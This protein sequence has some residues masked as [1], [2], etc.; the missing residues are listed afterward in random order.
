MIRLVVFDLDGTLV[1]SQ[2]DLANA[3]NALV[4]E[5]GGSA[6]RDEEVVAM[7][8]E[9][10]AVLVRRLLAAARLDPEQPGALARFLE[11]YDQR[12]TEN[13]IPYEGIE[14]VLR[15]LRQRVPLAVLTNKPQGVTN[16]LLGA[17]DLARHFAQVIGGDTPLGRKPDPAGLLRLCTDAG[18][19]PAE[20]VLVGDSPIDL[21][22]ARRAGTAILIAS[23]GFGYRFAAPPDDP[24]ASTPARILASLFGQLDT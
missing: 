16:R 20:T 11:L 3:G 14:E 19:H 21:E 5:L 9:G 10:A 22:T 8:G 4:V 24:T 2:Q 12:L 17:L 15:T 13:T 23:Y 18:V 6:L 7:V 1:D